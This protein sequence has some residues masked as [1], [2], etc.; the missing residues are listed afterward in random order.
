VRLASERERQRAAELAAEQERLRQEI[1]DLARR[2]K[3]R[4]EPRS[5]P[6]LARADSQASAAKGSL[7]EGDPAQAENQEAE[8]ERELRQA[9]SELQEEEEQYQRLRAEEQL[10]RI[11]EETATLLEAHRA[12]MKELA[13]VDAERAGADAPSR[14]Q[15]MRLRRIAR[16]EGVLGTRAQE[17]SGAIE[18]E[19]TKVAAGLL[20]GAASDLARLSKDLGEEG[21]YQT[22]ERVQGLQRD[23]EQALLWLLDALRAEQARRQNDRQKNPGGQQQDQGEP[24]LIPDSTELKLLKRMEEELRQSLDALRALHPELANQEELT[25]DVLRDIARLAGRHERLTELF[26]DL[27]GRV[28]IPPPESAED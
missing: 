5:R 21:D 27:R 11:A 13:E 4:D 18:K 14:A 12:Q 19:G 26:K 22:G 25:P 23:V 28:G 15:K 8:V 17:L 3:Q 9:Q 10:F 16:E 24:P 20:A 6:D 2:I 7:E 1:L